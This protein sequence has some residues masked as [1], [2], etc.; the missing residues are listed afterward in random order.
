[1]A[2]PL[3]FSCSLGFLV[4]NT[5]VRRSATILLLIYNKLC[6]FARNIGYRPSFFGQDGW[7]MAKFCFTCSWTDTCRVK[8]QKHAEKNEAKQYPAILSEKACSVKDLLFGFRAN[9][10]RVTPRVVPSG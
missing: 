10:S 7:I 5:S 6:M 2:T 9:F 8:V 3:S 1:M 4:D